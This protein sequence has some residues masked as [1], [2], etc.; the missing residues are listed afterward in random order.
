MIQPGA[1]RILIDT[2]IPGHSNRWPAASDVIDVEAL[3][4]QIGATLSPT[5]AALL[6]EPLAASTAPALLERLAAEH[7]LRCQPPLRRQLPRLLHDLGG[8][9]GHPRPRESG[10]REPSPDFDDSMLEQVRAYRR[11]QRRI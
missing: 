10:P 8:A 1:L 4:A 3:A 11:G 2:M 5:A 9:V 6:A 7:P